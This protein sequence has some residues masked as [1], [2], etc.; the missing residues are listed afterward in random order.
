MQ[1][2]LADSST[3]GYLPPISLPPVSDLELD[4]LIQGLI[5]GIT[6]LPGDLVLPRWQDQPE[7]EGGARPRIPDRATTWCAVGVTVTDSD[8]RPAL[9][10]SGEGDG[11]TTLRRFDTLDVLAT[12][13]G[14]KND[15]YARLVRDGFYISQNREEMYRNGLGFIGCDPIRRI[16]EI[17][18][19][20]TRRRSD[21]S[22]RLI[23]RV[24]R[25]FAILNVLEGVGTIIADGQ[26]QDGP[27]VTTTPFKAPET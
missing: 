18:G 1:A 19:M 24:E 3:G 8:D 27:M 4:T 6:G 11:S 25:T 13:Y 23:H 9:N 14:P 20:G 16:P 22:F 7:D 26:S 2:F 12:F 17:K 10:H 5:A 21:L 15:A